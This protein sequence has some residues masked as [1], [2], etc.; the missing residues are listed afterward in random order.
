MHWGKVDVLHVL[1]VCL[2]MYLSVFLPRAISLIHSLNKFLLTSTAYQ[3]S[4]LSPGDLQ[5][6]KALLP[7]TLYSSGNSLEV[8]LCPAS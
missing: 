1:G 7:R 2:G 6:T 5:Q 3:S 8:A 4:I